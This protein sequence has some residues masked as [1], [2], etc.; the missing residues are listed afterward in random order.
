MAGFDVFSAACSTQL[1]PPVTM[2]N[3]ATK[4]AIR[5][6]RQIVRNGTFDAKVFLT[7]LDLGLLSYGSIWRGNCRLSK[8][9]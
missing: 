5:T 7:L 9:A 8:P 6:M 4:N 2:K 3:I 1:F